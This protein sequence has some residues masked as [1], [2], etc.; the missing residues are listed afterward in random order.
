[1]APPHKARSFLCI[2]LVCCSEGSGRWTQWVGEEGEEDEAL[3]V[4]LEEHEVEKEQVGE[5]RK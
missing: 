2:W 1:M 5:V 3:Q 4:A